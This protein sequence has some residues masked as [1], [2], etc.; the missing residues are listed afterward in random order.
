MSESAAHHPDASTGPAKRSGWTAALTDLIPVGGWKYYLSIL[1]CFLPLLILYFRHLWMYE[2][3][4]YFPLLLIAFPIVIA[5]IRVT[6][7]APREVGHRW[8]LYL[9]L[10]GLVTLALAVLNWSPTLAA[11]AFAVTCGGVLR[12][13]YQSGHLS[14]F[15]SSWIVLLF[16][17]KLP[18]NID[19]DLVFWLSTLR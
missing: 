7:P 18:W 16:L 15:F 13:Y 10:A 2:H 12:H 1:I 14:R 6:D 19:V 8:E 11:I 17:I 9:V 4:R 3:Y 5:Q